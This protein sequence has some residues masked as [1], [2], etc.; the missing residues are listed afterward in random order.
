MYDVYFLQE[1][2]P[3]KISCHESSLLCNRPGRLP[4]PPTRPGRPPLLPGLMDHP[5]LLP[6]LV[7]HLSL[8]LGMVDH[9]SLLPGL[10]EEESAKDGLKRFVYKL[11]R[12]C[13]QFF[14][15]S[16]EWYL[17]SHKS[18]NNGISCYMNGKQTLLDQLHEKKKEKV[19]WPDCHLNRI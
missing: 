6:G 10:A 18:H 3:L 19:I 17:L 2:S 13:L 12:I 16:L 7:D 1:Y 8:L 14:F 5:S 11:F 4:H 9:A 15:L